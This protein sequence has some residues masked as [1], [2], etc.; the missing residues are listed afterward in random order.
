MIGYRMRSLRRVLV[1]MLLGVAA[2]QVMAAGGP[3]APTL[4]DVKYGPFERNVLDFW[5]AEGEGPRPLLVFIHGGAWMVGDKSGVGPSVKN[6]LDKGVSIAAINYRYS[7]QATLPAPVLDAA[8]AIQFLKSK[9]DQWNLRKDRFVLTGGSAGATTSMWILLHDDLADPDAKDPVLRE[10]T[11]VAAAGVVYPQTSIDPPVITKWIGP[12]VLDHRMIPTAVG[13]PNKAALLK[14]YEKHRDVLQEYSA[15]NHVDREDPPLLMV[16]SGK[17]SPPENKGY[18]IHHALFC[19]KMKEKSDE[20]GHECYLLNKYGAKRGKY[21]QLDDFLLDKLLDGGL[22][23]LGPVVQ[24]DQGNFTCAAR[25]SK[26][27]GKKI[28]TQGKADNMNIGYWVNPDDY[29][30]WELKVREPGEYRVVINYAAAKGNARIAA[31]AAGSVA[32]AARPSTGGF[33]QYRDLELGALTLPAGNV[34]LR[35]RSADGK[36]PMINLRRVVLTK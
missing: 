16:H 33:D 27:H 21:K 1:V 13:E 10:S 20:V 4:A 17:L 11:R 2:S 22:P 12:L 30:T 19:T 15:Y 32:E 8:R 36:R 3:P 26:L 9:A 28:T 24:D 5:R 35:I 25:Q 7:T 14:N 18:A 34:E 31:E 29:V 6:F 23:A